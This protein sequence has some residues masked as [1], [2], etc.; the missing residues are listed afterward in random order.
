MATYGPTYGRRATRP[1]PTDL[2]RSINVRRVL[3]AFGVRIRN[4]KRADC[5]LCKGNSNGTV[6]FTERFWRC[7]RCIEGGDVFSLVRAINRCDFPEA[8]RVVAHLAGIRMR[9]PA[10]PMFGAMWPPENNDA[11]A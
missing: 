8:H 3:C 4:S 2:A 7:H 6:A 11:S 10:D 1:S 5:P 9:T